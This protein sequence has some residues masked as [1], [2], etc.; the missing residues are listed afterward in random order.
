MNHR[1]LYISA[2][3]E[4]NICATMH[5]RALKELFNDVFIIDL[6]NHNKYKDRSL[7]FEKFSTIDKIKRV[8]ELNTWYLSNK[9]IKAICKF[10]QVHNISIIF[11][12]DSFFG[13]LSKTI[14]KQNS[15]I[16]IISFYHDIGRILYWQWLK[17]KGFKFLPQYISGIYGEYLT[18]KYSD[19]NFVLN[20]RDKLL[21]EKIYK[22]KVSGL[23]PISVEAPDLK[24]LQTKE[25]QFIKM[26]NEIY[27]L[28]V[29]SYYFPNITGLSWFVKNVFLK[30]PDFYR[31]IVVGRNMDKLKKQYSDIKNM[32]I[33]GEVASLAPYYN[34]AD[35]VIGPLF[36]GGGMKQ[37]T[38]EAIAYGKSFIGTKESLFGYEKCLKIKKNNLPLIY[39]ANTPNEFLYALNYI[40]ENK[41][42][43]FHSE[44]YNMYKTYY[45]LQATKNIISNFIEF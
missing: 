6:R 33:L 35:I 34:N 30:L 45:S 23:L 12:D 1:I 37:K 26:H 39:N 7:D 16:K 9:R 3:F 4:N 38:A 5:L 31:F 32:H 25:Y 18:Q 36:S 44:L 42:Y 28:F 22:K 43:G 19:Y 21:F 24:E 41:L 40:H 2:R 13:K 11:I 29:A 20:E 8:W 15:S 10:I 14:K 17:N 27:I